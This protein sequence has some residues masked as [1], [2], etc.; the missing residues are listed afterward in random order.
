MIKQVDILK[1]YQK[2]IKGK[3][4]KRDV[5]EFM[6]TAEENLVNLYKDIENAAYKHGPY[7]HFKINDPKPREIDKARIRDRII[8]Q[9][10]SDYLEKIF[11]RKFYFHSYASR[12]RKG[13]HAAVSSLQKMICGAYSRNKKT[14]AV[15]LDVKKFF[16]SVDKKILSEII[17]V[18]RVNGRYLKL[19][20]DLRGA[21]EIRKTFQGVDFLGYLIFPHHIV[22]R[23]KTKKR[24]LKKMALRKKE[25]AAGKISAEKFNQSLQSYL[26][27]LNHC[28]G[29]SLKKIICNI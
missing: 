23:T 29:S 8:H 27:A 24:I 4:K 9:A 10:V 19:I 12:K 21:A 14:Y 25:L 7:E 15:K 5:Q 26:G 16:H 11:E 20:L 17:S 3:R 6:L 18:Q 28:R 2:F 1:A 22:L 13:L